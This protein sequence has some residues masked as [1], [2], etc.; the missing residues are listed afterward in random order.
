MSSQAAIAGGKS[1]PLR[2]ATQTAR[3]NRSL[4]F[5]NPAR[6]HPQGCTLMSSLKTLYRALV[7]VAT[8]II[9]F[10]GWQHFGPSTDQLKTGITRALEVAQSALNAHPQ[11]AENDP[12]SADPRTAPPLLATASDSTASPAP[13]TVVSAPLSTAPSLQ[14]AAPAPP[15]LSQGDASSPSSPA[16]TEKLPALMSRLESLGVDEPKLA[17]WGSSGKLYRFCCRAKLGDTQDFAKHFESVADEPTA[18]VEQVVAK[19]E[20]WRLAQNDRNGLR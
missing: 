13:A 14:T 9:V 6:I 3:I 5:N 8:G 18:A 1:Q 12:T 15:L 16:E 20:A 2:F 10:L 4:A 19:V 11:R 7:M 17:P